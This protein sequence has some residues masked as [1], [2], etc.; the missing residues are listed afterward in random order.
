MA[1]L[2]W[3][4][5]LSVGVAAF[6]REHQGLIAIINELHDKMQAGQGKDVLAGLLKRLI[7]YT[8][9]HFE[10]EELELK[11]HAYPQLRDHQAQHAA[12]R[13]KVREFHNRLTIGYNGLIAV[14]MLRFLKSWLETHIQQEDRA[15]GR[16]LNG[17][18]IR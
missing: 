11:N 17:E 5:H 2:N 9:N 16:Y 10:H 15:Y 1:F 13:Q 18:G 6:D 14:E 3:G 7:D 12:L 8:I 4:P